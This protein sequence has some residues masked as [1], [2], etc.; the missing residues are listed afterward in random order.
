MLQDEFVYYAGLRKAL[1]KMLTE[2]EDA[3]D[4][5]YW[6]GTKENSLIRRDLKILFWEIC[7]EVGDF[8]FFI[9]REHSQCS[10]RKRGHRKDDMVIENFYVNKSFKDR[11]DERIVFSR[12]IGA[13]EFDCICPCSDDNLPTTHTTISWIA[14]VDTARERD[15]ILLAEA[16]KFILAAVDVAADRRPRSAIREMLAYAIMSLDDL[17]LPTPMDEFIANKLGKG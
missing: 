7:Q 17:L 16:I 11:F 15:C 3:G 2:F 9:L 1:F 5:P 12:P 13:Y 10:P 14:I 8:G 6:Y 4:N